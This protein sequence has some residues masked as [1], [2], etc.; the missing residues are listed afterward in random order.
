MLCEDINLTIEFVFPNYGVDVGSCRFHSFVL[1]RENQT[2]SKGVCVYMAERENR[3]FSFYSSFRPF[4]SCWCILFI[5]LIK[6]RQ[7]GRF[8]LPEMC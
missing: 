6:W 1:A 8:N 4:A 2:K 7:I 5:G 3:E